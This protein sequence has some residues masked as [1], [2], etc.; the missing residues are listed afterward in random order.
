MW[1]KYSCV[2]RDE[3]QEENVSSIEELNK[4][5][6]YK[7]THTD[8]TS[9]WH[10]NE[11]GEFFGHTT[12]FDPTWASSPWSGGWYN[13][14]QT[15][16]FWKEFFAEKFFSMFFGNR[17]MDYGNVVVDEEIVY[18]KN[19][20]LSNIKNSKV[21]VLGGGPS[22]DDLD[23]DSLQE[24]DFIIS[25][26][27]YYQSEKLKDVKVD[28][29]LIGQGTNLDDPELIKRIKKDNTLIGFEHSH[30]LTINI[31]DQFTKANDTDTFLYL[32]RYFSRLGFASR[33]IVLATCFGAGKIDVVGF[34]G[35]RKQKED[36][37]GF[38]KK[39]NL[40]EY[41]NTIKY[42]EAA[43]VFWDYLTTHFSSEVNNLSESSDYNVYSGIKDH[44]LNEVEG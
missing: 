1:D 34:D 37:H 38:E 10:N 36:K 17:E 33:A 13:F 18:T 16:M 15:K 6:Q 7:S 11:T 14:N 39:K 9:I 26:N 8:H 30:K 40:P 24:Y 29:A 19:D 23:T 4:L 5:F 12:R 41:Y 28:I 20:R 32:T 3:D 43:V 44:V 31:I 22:L 25:C 21:L 42:E 35:H 2:Y 27:N